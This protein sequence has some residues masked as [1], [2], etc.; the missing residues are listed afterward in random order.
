MVEDE[1]ILYTDIPWA[2]A[3]Y[4]N[5]TS[6]LLPEDIDDVEKITN[7]WDKVGGVYLT[8][9]TVNRPVQTESSWRSLWLQKAPL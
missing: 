2:T 7:G 1:E 6:V 8:S 5:R 9:E 4:G 3:W